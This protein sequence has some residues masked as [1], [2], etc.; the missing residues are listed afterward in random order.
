MQLS[1]YNNCVDLHDEYLRVKL[2][3]R[4]IPITDDDAF[5]SSIKDILTDDNFLECKYYMHHGN[6]SC[7]EHQLSVA[8]YTYKMCNKLGLRSEEAARGA[9]L[10]DFFLYDWHILDK[11]KRKHH[12]TNHPKVALEN[13]KKYFDLTDMQED[14]IIKHMWPL[15]ILP[16]KYMETFI[17]TIADKMCCIM[18]VLTSL[19]GKKRNVDCK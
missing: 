17:V 4:Y 1:S 18:E 14:I 15:T 19:F 10:H 13:A 5:L 6:T 11:E 3:R 16:P 12:A 8:Y 9:L 2:F 7:Y